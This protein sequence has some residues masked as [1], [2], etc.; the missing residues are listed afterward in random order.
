MLLDPNNQELPSKL[1]TSKNLELLTSSTNRNQEPENSDVSEDELEILQIKVEKD[2]PDLEDL[3]STK[4]S[5]VT[6]NNGEDCLDEVA[7]WGSELPGL[8]SRKMG[9]QV[10][11]PSGQLKG[12]DLPTKNSKADVKIEKKLE[13]K[14]STSDEDCAENS[15]TLCSICSKCGK[16]F[17]VKNDLLTHICVDIT[18]NS[19]PHSEER[20]ATCSESVESFRTSS[21]LS[22]QQNHYTEEN[23]FQ[24]VECGMSFFHESSLL[25]HHAMHLLVKRFSCTE[26]GK[27]FCHRSS[28]L[29]HERNHKGEKPFTCME[30]GKSFSRKSSLHS[31]HKIHT[32]EKPFACTECGKSFHA[33]SDL[34]KHQK[35]HTGEKP[36][37][38]MECGKKFSLNSNL[39]KHIKIH[40]RENISHM[41]KVFL[42]RITF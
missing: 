11:G 5:A 31:H 4:N 36:F 41:G 1:S 25:S 33:K 14:S 35:S 2:E 15:E 38:C 7:N 20:S 17:S 23:S 19:F 30:C 8:W 6:L 13:L 27:K 9:K 32:G 37:T 39:H 29:N 28:L 10:P 3:K 18:D 21:K 40:Q 26:C 22:S 24:C 34:H 42:E 12:L 16:A